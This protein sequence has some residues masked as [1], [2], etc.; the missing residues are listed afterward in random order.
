M[1]KNANQ[2]LPA[3]FVNALTFAGSNLTLDQALKTLTL[4]TNLSVLVDGEPITLSASFNVNGTVKD[5][6]DKISEAFDY[7]WRFST[8]G[9]VIMSKRFTN[10]AERPQLNP[11][12]MAGMCR[13]MIRALTIID[14]DK[15]EGRWAQIVQEVAATLPANQVKAL[16]SGEILHGSDLTN[17]QQ[18]AL[19]RATLSNTFV[20][21]LHIW[22]S[23]LPRLEGM[24]LGQLGAQQREG[25]PASPGEP[26]YD[27]Q[28][29]FRVAGGLMNFFEIPHIVYN[30]GKDP[31][32][33][34]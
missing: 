8:T 13:D 16:R 12:E 30:N 4:A 25:H 29:L 10:R 21:P 6:M 7:S 17:T 1:Q 24:R 19:E 20:R 27:Y 31:E 3:V 9:V 11:I 26:L 34:Q 15:D 23:L 32:I 2:T 22:E 28:Y 18:L 5:S 14:Y 33:R